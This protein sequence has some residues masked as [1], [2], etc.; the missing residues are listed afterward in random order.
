MSRKKNRVSKSCKVCGLAFEV[1]A[2]SAHA[3][4]TCSRACSLKYRSIFAKGRTVRRD[5]KWLL[6]KLDDYLIKVLKGPPR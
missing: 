5:A 1:V 2:S 6:E 4:A 3:Y